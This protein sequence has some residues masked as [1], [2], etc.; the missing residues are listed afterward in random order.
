LNADRYIKE[1]KEQIQGLLDQPGQ[2]RIQEIRQAYQDCMTEHCGVFRTDEVMQTGLV[3][4][5]ELQQKYS[6]VRLDDRG[7]SWN[8]ELIE[9]LELR[10]L[11]VVGEMILFSAI[12]RKESRG[13]HFRE[14]Y[15][16]RDDASFLKHTLA[17]YSAAGI[18]INYMP[19][20]LNQFEPQE[21]K[22]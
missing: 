21:R 6:Q 15:D 20:V 4:L 5:R 3:K 7:T 13:S 22:Y 9:A 1:A 12:N 18:D 11:F 2:Y 19:V 14:D 16:Q 17:Y 10:S 8:T